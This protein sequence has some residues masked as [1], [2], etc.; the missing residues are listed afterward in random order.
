MLHQLMYIKQRREKGLRNDL[1]RVLRLRKQVEQEI[2]RLQQQQR[3]VLKAWRLACVQF[4]GKVDRQ[5]L[6]SWQENMRSYQ[7]Q[8]ENVGLQLTK[9]QLQHASLIDDESHLQAQLRLVMVAQEKIN[10]MISVDV[11]K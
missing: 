2:S 4:T 1:A 3:D 5:G 7:L 6:I 11:E 9:Q 8:Y 10:Y